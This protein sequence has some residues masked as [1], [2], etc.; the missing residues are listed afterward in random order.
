MINSH[1]SMV[2]IVDVQFIWRKRRPLGHTEQCAGVYDGYFFITF[3]LAHQSRLK[4][5]CG[6]HNEMSLMEFISFKFLSA[7]MTGKAL[8]IFQ[9]MCVCVQRT[10]GNSHNFHK[11]WIECTHARTHTHIFVLT[12]SHFAFWWESASEIARDEECG[13]LVVT[14]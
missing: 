8:L 10:V 2:V 4:R 11:G 13:V 1:V 3:K 7:R 14:N 12:K 9:K 6:Y 5:W